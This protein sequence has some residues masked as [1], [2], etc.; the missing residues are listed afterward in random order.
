MIP[1]VTPLVRALLG[2]A[3]DYAGLFPPAGLGMSRAVANY[4]EY[5]SSEDSW[6]LG[7]F[8]I[9][10]SRLDE[11]AMAAEDL[12]S[13]ASVSITFHLSVVAGPDVGTD[14]EM[15]L[16]YGNEKQNGILVDAVELKASTPREIVG[17]VGIIPGTHEIYFEIPVQE[18]PRGL[19]ET[20]GQAGARAK[21]R[22]GGVTSDGFPGARDLARFIGAC[23]DSHVV[24]KATA[25]LHH[26]VRSQ[27]RL[28]Y[29]KDSP[30]G[31]MFGFLNVFLT[32]A[33]IMQGLPSEQAIEL[34][35]ERSPRALHFEDEMVVWRGLS[36]CRA[37]IAVMRQRVIAS[38]GSCSFREP[39]DE[40]RT[41]HLL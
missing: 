40:L 7:K 32:A 23:I 10:A 9:P 30:M 39:I 18:D 16:R 8:V 22:T 28:T 38:F 1:E 25:G 21:V 35:E 37:D 41:L 5:F 26:A 6:A 33:F 17:A 24:F 4:A 14:V 2:G 12:N 3:I 31:M 36:V 29:E 15:L 27:Y 34:L 20:I 11:F 13:K 19:I